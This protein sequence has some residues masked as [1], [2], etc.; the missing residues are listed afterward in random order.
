METTITFV[1]LDVH[2]SSI[3]VAVAEGDVRRAARF[4]GQIANT[5]GAL[6]KLAK[7]LARKGQRLRFCYEAGPCGYGVWRHLRGLGHDCVVVAPSLIPRK[8]GDRVKTDR[9]PRLPGS[10]G[11]RPPRRLDPGLGARRRS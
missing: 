8:P 1:G 3:S 10:G 7:K 4:M 9:P 6:S 2:K 11:A 5:P